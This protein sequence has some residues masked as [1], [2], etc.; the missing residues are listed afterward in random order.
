MTTDEALAGI[1]ARMGD[2]YADEAEAILARMKTTDDKLRAI[3]IAH[4]GSMEVAHEVA[5]QL[6]GKA[7][8]RAHR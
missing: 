4:F 7:G 8:L 1:R 5:D 6:L 3:V 2:A